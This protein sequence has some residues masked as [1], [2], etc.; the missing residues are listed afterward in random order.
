[1]T[2][3]HLELVLPAVPDSIPAIRRAVADAAVERHAD[4]AAVDSV[5]LAVTEAVTNVVRHAYGDKG[6]DI[7]VAVEP[8]GDTLVVWV[9]DDGAGIVDA[10]FRDEGGYG[11]TLMRALSRSCDVSSAAAGGTSI[12][13]VFSLAGEDER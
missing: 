3:A 1:M 2:Q 12:R 9:V 6:G 13:M 8:R 5:R 4:P 10:P 11:L 7:R